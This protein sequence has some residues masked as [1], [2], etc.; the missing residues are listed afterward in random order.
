MSILIASCYSVSEN[1]SDGICHAAPE[2]ADGITRQLGPSVHN[3]PK[4]MPTK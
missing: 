4:G 2:V 1:I 3:A